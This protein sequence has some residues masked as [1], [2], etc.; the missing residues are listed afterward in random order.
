VPYVERI[1]SINTSKLVEKMSMAFPYCHGAERR[2]TKNCETRMGHSNV[3]DSPKVACDM[4]EAT[5]ELAG[6]LG[7]S[8]AEERGTSED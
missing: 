3:I 4:V 2:R 5:K 8:I 1:V 7:I 6:L